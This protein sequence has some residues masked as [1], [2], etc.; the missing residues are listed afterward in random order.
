[1][2]NSTSYGSVRHI[3]GRHKPSNDIV[4]ITTY[5][6]GS[7]Q[8]G[9]Q[10][11]TNRYTTLSNRRL[12]VNSSVA[13][14]EQTDNSELPDIHSLKDSVVLPNP[15]DQSV[16]NEDNTKLDREIELNKH[17]LE[18]QQHIENMERLKQIRNSVRSVDQF[19]PIKRKRLYQGIAIISNRE[20]FIDIFKTKVKFYISCIELATKQP[21]MIELYLNQGKKLLHE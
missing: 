4:N 15:N 16:F 11:Q 3:F 17:Y 5:D 1:M 6:D 9:P 21:H 19:N 2:A 14:K 13:S 7:D 18:E 8:Y 10:K 12:D 20:L